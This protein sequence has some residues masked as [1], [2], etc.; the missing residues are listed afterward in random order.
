MRRGL[1]TVKKLGLALIIINILFCG[2]SNKGS[3]KED[4]SPK[5]KQLGTEEEGDKIPEQLKSIENSIE[6]I[7]KTLDGP[8]VETKKNGL[9]EDPQDK[10]KQDIVD[11]NPQ[12]NETMQNPGEKQNDKSKEEKQSEEKQN[13]QG[14]N[15]E[16]PSTAKEDKSC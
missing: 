11:T 6:S 16:Q 4:T 13:N 14:E 5:Q 1:E 15:K 2:C 9:Q 7:I 3:N 12:N 10:E 8:T